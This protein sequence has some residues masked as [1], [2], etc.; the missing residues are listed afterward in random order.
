MEGLE[1]GNL[2]R[3]VE[4]VSP[5]AQAGLDHRSGRSGEGS[6]AMHHGL[7]P[8]EP[9]VQGGSVVETEDPRLEAQPLGQRPDGGFGPAGDDRRC[10]RSTA[11]CA[12]RAPV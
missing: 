11:I 1:D 5:G 4:V 3:D 2:A 8:V 10:P 6:G 12:M 7:G 9:L